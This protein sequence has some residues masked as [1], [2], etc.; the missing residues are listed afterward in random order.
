MREA[1]ISNEGNGG[2]IN[3][4][5][6]SSNADAERAS[7]ASRRGKATEKMPAGMTYRLSDQLY[8]SNMSASQHPQTEGIK[9]SLS[10]KVFT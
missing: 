1:A 3:Q 9:G 10:E 8:L 6:N 5:P 4:S 2:E 7:A